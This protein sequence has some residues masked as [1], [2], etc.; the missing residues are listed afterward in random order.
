MPPKPKP[1]TNP[2]GLAKDSDWQ[3]GVQRTLPL[4]LEE[5]WSLLV[6]DVGTRIWLG[7]KTPPDPAPGARYKTPDGTV[8]EIRSFRVCDRVRLTWRPKAWDHDSTIEATLTPSPAGTT[9]RFHQER[10][11]S[12]EEREAMRAHWQHVLDALARHLEAQP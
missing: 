9:L 5:A 12:Q 3:V 4:D 2:T 11:A 8:G 10:L 1:T 6:S 7:T